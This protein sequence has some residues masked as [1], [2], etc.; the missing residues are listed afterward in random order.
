[1]KLSMRIV[2]IATAVALL[3]PVLTG[4]G[5][6]QKK[7][8]STNLTYALSG[9]IVSLDP[10]YAYDYNTNVVTDQIT[11]S[12][13]AYD[14]D[15][16][17]INN[18]TKSWKRVNDT[19]YVY[20]IRND[21]KFSDGTAMTMDD[22]L[23]SINRYMDKVTASYLAWMYDSV[24]SVKQ[25]GDWELTVTLSKPDALWQYVFATSAGDIISEKYYKAHSSNFGK[26]AGGVLGTGPYTF[27]SWTTGSQIV[28]EKNKNY[29]NKDTAIQATRV[30]Y[31]I[32]SENT[33][34]VNALTSGQADMAVN[35][36]ADMLDQITASKNLNVSKIDSFAVDFIAFNC[37]RA[38]FT[39]QNVRKAI[40]Y[41]IDRDS[42]D[43]NVV[44]ESGAAA[45]SLLMGS[46]LFTAE[47]NSWTSYSKS[48]Q[49][50][51]YSMDK[52]KE[53]LA[54]SAYPD[55]FTC[56]LVTNQDSIKV[57]MA[58][59][60][61][62]ALK[63]LNINVNIQKVS[64]DELISIQFG[65]KMKDGKRDYDMILAMW[66]SDFPDISGN[67]KP[68]LLSTNGGQGGSNTAAYS[69]SKVDEL[70]NQQSISSDDKL[71][72]EK[73]QQAS[74]IAINDAAYVI[75]D[76]PKKI[77]VTNKRINNF[78]INASWVYDMFFKDVKFK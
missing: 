62:S 58:L 20:E 68:L 38:P 1:M 37:Q 71:R 13:L 16:K 2:A 76:Y 18:L 32:I 77:L 23:F 74:D 8:A 55:G 4:C 56:T 19:T 51:D 72:T 65:G 25:T 36:P 24:K 60:V 69:S 59:A 70:L 5:S 44:K 11:E 3:V 61:Q 6:S 46:A 39:D 43:T 64:S 75:V 52:A 31:K 27:K 57:S 17:I 29:W 73:L 34:L 41:A 53:Y 63:N 7:A 49:T 66:E 67:I 33:T 26:P 78:T 14:A 12:L 10:V 9:D 21:V 30:V 54:K 47:K 45:T 42:I 22:V 40:Y 28:L 50:Y 35:P 15:N 48:A